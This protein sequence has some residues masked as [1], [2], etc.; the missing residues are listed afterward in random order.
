MPVDVDAGELVDADAEL[1]T[2]VTI[3]IV[4]VGRRHH[5]SCVVGWLR[6]RVHCRAVECQGMWWRPLSSRVVDRMWACSWMLHWR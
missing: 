4:V 5:C 1:G 6:V 3:G 2:L